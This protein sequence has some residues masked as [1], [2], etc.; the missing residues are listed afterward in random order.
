MK[1]V[2]G[3]W[4]RGGAQGGGACTLVAEEHDF[5]PGFA[6]LLRLSCRV[7]VDHVIC[8]GSPHMLVSVQPSELAQCFKRDQHHW[9]AELVA[10]L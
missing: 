10:A 7:D 6:K 8:S 5:V 1:S 9:E 4:E 2:L 3:V